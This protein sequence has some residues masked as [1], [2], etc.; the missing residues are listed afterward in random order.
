MFKATKDELSPI[1]PFAKFA[2]VKAVV[3]FSFWQSV[4]IQLVAGWKPSIFGGHVCP[5]HHVCP[6]HVSLTFE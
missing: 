5:F 3:F 6:L 1:R 2:V 4:A